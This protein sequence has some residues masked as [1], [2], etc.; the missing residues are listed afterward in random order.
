MGRAALASPESLLVMQNFRLQPQY[1]R[2]ESESTLINP[3]VR[4]IYLELEKQCVKE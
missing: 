1:I 4:F 2:T 3:Q